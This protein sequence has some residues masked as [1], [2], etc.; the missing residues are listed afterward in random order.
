MLSLQGCCLNR[1]L[2]QGTIKNWDHV[3]VIWLLDYNNTS[4]MW[5]PMG[6]TEGAHNWA[7]CEQ[8]EQSV[9]TIWSFTHRATVSEGCSFQIKFLSFTYCISIIMMVVVLCFLLHKLSYLICVLAVDT[10]SLCIIYINIIHETQRCQTWWVG[11]DTTI[12]S[13]QMNKNATYCYEH[14]TPC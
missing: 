10:Y 9:M 13:V 12:V 7:K 1:A 8:I 5:T 3:D 14:A 4:V 11:A 2:S 6:L